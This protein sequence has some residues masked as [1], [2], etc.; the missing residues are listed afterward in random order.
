MISHLTG[1]IILKKPTYIILEVNGVGYQIFCNE[2]TLNGLKEGAE[3]VIHTHHH[4]KEDLQELYGFLN[5]PELELFKNVIG[6]SG[7]GP[8]TGLAV[9]AV[10]SVEDI[11]QAILSENPGL[12]RTVS[13]IGTKTA[14]RLVVELKS[15]IGSLAKEITGKDLSAASPNADVIEALIGL[16]YSRKEV[17]EVARQVPNDIT[18]DSERIKGALKLLGKR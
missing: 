17:M 9:L 2:K 15:K 4:V 13:G 7:V 14:E 10:A 5:L 3:A 16:G 12:L 1:K 6:I 11:I 8:K 18:D